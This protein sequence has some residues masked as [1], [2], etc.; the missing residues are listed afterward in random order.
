M[1]SSAPPV[2]L[3]PAPERGVWRLGKGSAPLRY[4][5]I[6]PETINGSAAGRFSLFTYGTLYCASDLAGCFAEALAGFRVD[7][8]M[9]S[10]MSGD[11]E[12]PGPQPM[13]LGHL[14][15]SWRQ[16]RILVRL[17]PAA[18]ARFLDV[19][20]EETREVLADELKGD[21]SEWDVQPPLE[22]HHIHGPDRRIARQIAAWSVAQRNSAGHQLIQGI[23]YRSGYGGRRCWAILSTTELAEAERR[24][25]LAESVELQEVAREYGLTVW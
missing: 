24:P 23:A 5:Q 4:N 13:R 12:V 11:E 19:D 15:S 7:P 18:E 21:L 10:L 16:E 6:E 22:D 3:V 17:M 25:V 2:A 1:S 14:A 8:R 9:R 20:A